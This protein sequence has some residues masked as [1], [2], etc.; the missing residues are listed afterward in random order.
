M[1]PVLYAKRFG[2]WYFL[3]QPADDEKAGRDVEVVSE[4]GLTHREFLPYVAGELV[5]FLGRDGVR[6]DVSVSAK[7]GLVDGADRWW[8]ES[9]SRE[10]RTY[11]PP[12]AEGRSE[13]VPAYLNDVHLVLRGGHSRATVRRDGE[14]WT[15]HIT[16]TDMIVAGLPLELE[17]HFFAVMD[18]FGIELVEGGAYFDTFLNKDRPLEF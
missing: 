10:L 12:D 14:E 6:L 1:I 17:A 11:T 3:Y 18:A 13:Y 15:F 8:T 7:T 4:T 2:M 9:P 5:Y 16:D